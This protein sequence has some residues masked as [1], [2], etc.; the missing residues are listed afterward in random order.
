MSDKIKGVAQLKDGRK[1]Y[2]LYWK[3]STVVIT[4]NGKESAHEVPKGMVV[5]VIPIKP[6]GEK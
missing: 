5:K 4:P 2:I 1:E 6:K 3:P